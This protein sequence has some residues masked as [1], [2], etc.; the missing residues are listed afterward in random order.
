[1]NEKSFDE[2]LSAYLDRELPAEQSREVENLLRNPRTRAILAELHRI[3]Q[4]IQSLP[5]LDLPADLIPV[6]AG[7]AAQTGDDG[8]RDRS[9]A[10]LQELL[11]TP[12][13]VLEAYA[14]DWLDP[15]Q[16][17]AVE[18]QLLLQ[19]NHREVISELAALQAELRQMP[20]AVVPT[21]L[22][23]ATMDRLRD[24][25]R[26][27]VSEVR[28]L[29][30]TQRS[31][32]AD[33]RLW[34]SV[35]LLAASVVLA[36]AALTDFH[37]SRQRDEINNQVAMGTND[38]SIHNDTIIQES[39]V[40]AEKKE[41]DKDH[42]TPIALSG[43]VEPAANGPKSP[44]RGNPTISER[45]APTSGAPARVSGAAGNPVAEAVLS[46]DQLSRLQ[47]GDLLT[48]HD[49]QL[50]LVCIDVE[51]AADRLQILF[52]EQGLTERSTD[53]S[54]QRKSDLDV[55][56]T[57]TRPH[58]HVFE[59][60][61]SPAQLGKVFA[62]LQSLTGPAGL[63]PEVKFSKQN[64]SPTI[65]QRETHLEPLIREANPPF[66]G[67]FFRRWHFASESPQPL[68]KQADSSEASAKDDN[69]ATADASTAQ[70][71]TPLQKKVSRDNAADSG[72]PMHVLIYVTPKSNDQPP[73]ATSQTDSKK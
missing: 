27:K 64:R 61:A 39:N 30:A 73:A 53:I 31:N 57:G 71:A 62:K 23:V 28:A 50:R 43:R 24:V 33:T 13:R 40:V 51:H 8:L 48:L 65:G 46:I 3:T 42:E 25:D 58:M 34:R 38:H 15:Q 49:Q 67:A 2:M 72:I 6:N 45:V 44:S 56:Q 52:A 63:Q 21:E 41:L 32:S 18:E 4:A 37:G 17:R 11:T 7:S 36:F 10:F 9:G 29:P 47:P 35:A 14:D 1:M 19:P 22:A 16:R 59:V 26:S 54:D 68:H 69:P 12:E 20:R 66:A 60:F 5:S 70:R 55:G